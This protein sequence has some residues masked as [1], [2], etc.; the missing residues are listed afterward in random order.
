MLMMNTFIYVRGCGMQTVDRAL[1]DSLKQTAI[2][3]GWDVI[4]MH[5]DQEYQPLFY[6]SGICAIYEVMKHCDCQLLLVASADQLSISPEQLMRF[7]TLVMENEMCVFLQLE[8]Q[9]LNE[10]VYDFKL[11]NA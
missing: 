4:A 11:L 8:Q 10:W 1:Y 9:F 7:N 6:P 3:H 2:E 5:I